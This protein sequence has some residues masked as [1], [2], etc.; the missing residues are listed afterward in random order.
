MIISVDNSYSIGVVIINILP[1]KTRN[2]YS[3]LEKESNVVILDL[4]NQ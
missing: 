1:P 4:C 3:K 2:Y